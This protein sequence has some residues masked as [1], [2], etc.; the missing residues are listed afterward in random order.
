MSVTGVSNR[1]PHFD[2]VGRLRLWYAISGVI[3]AACIVALGVRNLNLSIE[4]VGGSAFT[5]SGVSADVT[6]AGLEDAATAAGADDAQA[7]LVRDA[8]RATGAIVRTRPIEPGTD[9]ESVVAGALQEAADADEVQVDFVGPTWGERIS[10]KMIEA[11]VVFLVV[12]VTYISL[13]LEFKMSVAA[14]LALFHDVVLTA[15]VYALF[16]FNVSS[17]TVIAL[18]TI[19]GYSLYDTAI[20]FDRVK[21]TSGMLGRPGRRTYSEAVNTSMN[22]VLQRSVN[23]TVSSILPV[24]ALLF[25]GAQ[26]LG[27]T[28]LQDLAVAL[29]VGMATG[30]YSSL[31]IAGPFLAWWKE[32]E[33][34]MQQ[35][36]VRAERREPREQPTPQQPAREGPEQPVVVPVGEDDEASRRPTRPATG[37]RPQRRGPSQHVRGPGRRP[38]RKR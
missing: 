36:A 18:L 24:G 1:R 32:R 7:Q 23:T 30:A 26:A 12:V 3:V 11:L 19:L 17:A 16:Q 20:V 8:G 10:R 2:F 13:R 37:D 38:R 27:A 33:P 15:G 14:L 5:V 4:F 21:E 22:E 31:F 28:T 34:K 9:E 6:A 25:I 29:F 35:L